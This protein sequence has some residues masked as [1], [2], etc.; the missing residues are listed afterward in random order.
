MSE[1]YAR[2]MIPRGLVAL[3]IAAAMTVP[4]GFG[5]RVRIGGATHAQS[6]AR[7]LR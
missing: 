4:V 6:A 5:A 2:N 7:H 3:A 1:A